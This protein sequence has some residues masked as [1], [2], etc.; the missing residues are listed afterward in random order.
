VASLVVRARGAA[1]SSALAA[2]L[3]IRDFRVYWWG[4]SLA[5]AGDFLQ[6]VALAVLVLDLTQSA[7]ALGAVMTAQALPRTLLMLLGGVVADRVR[8]RSIL[9]R[10]S[11][12]QAVLGGALAIS[13]ASGNLAL[14]Q[15]YAYGLAVGTLYAFSM[16]A[17]QSII[18]S[19]VPP[20]QVR[21]ANSLNS[22][23]LNL[24]MFLIPPATGV[25]VAAAGVAPAFFLNA[26]CWT[27]ATLCM[28]AVRDT[29]TLARSGQGMIAQLREGLGIVRR[30]EVLLVAT[31]AAMVFSLG[32]T[33]VTQVGVPSLAKLDL[34]AGNP[35]VG[36]LFGASGLGAL[37]GALSIGSLARVPRMGLVASTTLIAMGL[38][39][40]ATAAAPTLLAAA[41][42]LFVGGVAR[43]FAGVTFV[44]ITQ[45]NAPP[46]ARGRVMALFMLG[47]TGL[48]PLS[49]SIGGLLAEA[50]GVRGV[51][52]AGGGAI[53]IAGLFAFSR[54]AFR[55][56]E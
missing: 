53:A 34:G 5:H 36:M 11:P 52:I 28:L 3:Q 8:P 17:Q 42:L 19:L 16:P 27:I 9:T 56:V 44:T 48:A 15:L 43:A 33:G 45:T 31:L 18:P 10:T 14:W 50:L 24:V 41:T 12:A 54:T 51:F 13:I 22:T 20:E 7:A 6:I 35:G 29:P 21:S 32:F 47:V 38:A 2:P 1:R 25:L 26:V 46:E 30:N 49:L 55:R 23:T 40:A 37:I 4:N 39:L